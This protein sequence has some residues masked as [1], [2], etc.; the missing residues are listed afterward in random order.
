VTRLGWDS[1]ENLIPF[2]QALV[3]AGA[4]ALSIHGRRYCDKFTG[5]ADWEPIYELKKAVNGL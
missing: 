5:K 3:S 2:C 4:K 1:K